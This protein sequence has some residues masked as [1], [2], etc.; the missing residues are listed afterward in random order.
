MDYVAVKDAKDMRGLRLAL[1][2]GVPGPFGEAAK[3]VLKA[4]AVAF[5]PVP[6]AV[7]ESNDDL[8]EWTGHRNAPVAVYDDEKPRIGWAEILFLAERL[9]S[10]PSLIPADPAERALMMGLS[11]ELLGENGL[12]WSRRLSLVHPALVAGPSHPAYEIQRFIG[13]LYGYSP[14]A[15]EAAEGRAASILTMLSEQLG[16]Q[17]A[18][19]KR[20]LVGDAFSAVDIYWAAAASLVVPLPHEQCPMGPP[21][22]AM[23]ESAP[24][25]LRATASPELLGHRDFIFESVLGLPMDF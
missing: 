9:G 25:A 3:G 8:V 14:K 4:R 17:H 6:Q 15:G 1:S 16:A 18:R 20:Y 19:G 5:V 12:V 22:R 10:G 7:G 21:F 2:A 13:D 24:P 11:H 23:Y